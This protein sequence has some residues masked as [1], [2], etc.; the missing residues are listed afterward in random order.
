M[1]PRA[2]GL[3]P[4]LKNSSEF[5]GSMRSLAAVLGQ[6]SGVEITT[7][8]VTRRY[9]SGVGFVLDPL[10]VSTYHT[11]GLLTGQTMALVIIGKRSRLISV[12]FS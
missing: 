10:R 12:G 6:P 3:N 2:S 5:G 11:Q 9:R 8:V 1:I 4:T 7:P